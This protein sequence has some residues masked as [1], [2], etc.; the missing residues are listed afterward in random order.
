MDNTFL[1]VYTHSE[2]NM[3]YKYD[4]VYYVFFLTKQKRNNKN[5]KTGINWHLMKL[6]VDLLSVF[7]FQC[8]LKVLAL[9]EINHWKVVYLK[10]VTIPRIARW[11][12]VKC[13]DV[14]SNFGTSYPTIVN[15]LF[16]RVLMSWALVST[17][18]V[19]VFM[20]WESF[21]ELW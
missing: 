2:K 6:Y 3:I 4:F 15:Y 11:Q 18:I 5:I 12:S 14:L 19:L 17:M 1:Y 8:C 9:M 16:W 21:N 13:S 10:I 7:L 20:K